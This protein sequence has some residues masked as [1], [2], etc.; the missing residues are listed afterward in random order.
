MTRLSTVQRE[1]LSLMAEH[2]EGIDGDCYDYGGPCVGDHRHP[3]YRTIAAMVRDGWITADR[4]GWQ[5][6]AA[7]RATIV[8]AQP[9]ADAPREG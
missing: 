9:A 3:Q 7:G 6:T 5:I 4:F 2:D 1:I 8:T